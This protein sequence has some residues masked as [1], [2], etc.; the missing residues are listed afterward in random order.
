MIATDPHFPGL[1]RLGALLA[2]PGRA[3]MLWALMD[4]SARPAGELTLLAGLSPSAGS[5]HLARLTD[6]GLLSLEVRGRHRYYRI[7]SPEVAASIETLANLAQATAPLR[8]VPAVARTVPLEMR[9]A[10]T[11]YDHMAGELAVRVYDRMR[12]RGWL[13]AA[14]GEAD[15]PHDLEVTPLGADELASR[16]RI[17]IGTQRRR[18]RRFA[19]TCLDWSERRAHLAGALGAALLDAWLAQHW[20]EPAGK[21][22]VLRITPDGQRRFEALLTDA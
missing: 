3:A 2:D 18:R 22:R 19:C 17:D 20:I 12:E 10:R 13:A 7:A 4:G 16:W 9:H 15:D 8:P 11:C 5:A 1:S 21:P 6:G 14:N